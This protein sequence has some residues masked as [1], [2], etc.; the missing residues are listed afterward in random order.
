[1]VFI[2]DN[3]L[4]TDKKVLANVPMQRLLDCAKEFMDQWT[5]W[6]EKDGNDQ[7]LDK[8]FLQDLRGLSEA[9]AAKDVTDWLYQ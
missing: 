7:D 2:S 8:Q 5:S 4:N 3:R 9:L 6:Q 1:M